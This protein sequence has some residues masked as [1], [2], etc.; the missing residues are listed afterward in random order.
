MFS[1][2][3][4]PYPAPRPDRT[5]VLSGLFMGLFVGLFLLYFR[6]FDLGSG[7]FGEV[8]V[9]IVFF[10]VITLFAYWFMEVL[11]PLVFPRWF[12]DQNWKVWHRIAY[13]LL[14]LWL[15]ASLNGLYTNYIQGLSFSWRNYGLIMTQTLTL[16]V[17]PITMIVLYR[18]NEKMVFYLKEAAVMEKA[19]HL[20]SIEPAKTKAKQTDKDVFLAAEAYGN[21][22][23]VHYASE[24]GWRQE[25]Q[26]LTLSSLVA[27]LSSAGV[28]R[29]HR[30]FAVHPGEV[31]YVSGNAQGLQ[32]LLGEGELEV[33]VSRTYLKEVREALG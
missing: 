13:Y 17:L 18:Y 20:R 25:V 27:D 26:R 4:S 16:G 10:G 19:S 28:V 15:I 29:C 30:S 12:N 21:Y 9:R 14:I 33:P 1:K 11:L 2:L 24:D 22:V 8:P 5:A 3:T 32:L 23:K 7:F 31:R 6:P